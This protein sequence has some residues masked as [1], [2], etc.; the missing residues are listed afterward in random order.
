MCT[1]L[2]V[3][4]KTP[5]VFPVRGAFVPAEGRFAAAPQPA[6]RGLTS[7]MPWF[8]IASFREGLHLRVIW[9]VP[10]PAPPSPR[11]HSPIFGAH[12]ARSSHAWLIIH[13]DSTRIGE[14]TTCMIRAPALIGPVRLRVARSKAVDC[15]IRE[16]NSSPQIPPRPV[17]CV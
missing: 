16:S 6:F 2:L 9:R 15:P 5:A 7:L 11:P 3:I 13:A 8:R 14:T 4:Q 10:A 17:R 1:R 12:L